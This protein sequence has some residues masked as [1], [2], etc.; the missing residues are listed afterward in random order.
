M[1]SIAPKREGAH[2]SF[3]L[4]SCLAWVDGGWFTSGLLRDGF[5]FNN[6]KY[7]LFGQQGHPVF[8]RGWRQSRRDLVGTAAAVRCLS[9]CSLSRR[10]H[11]LRLSASH[12][13]PQMPATFPNAPPHSQ[14]RPRGRPRRRYPR[15]RHRPHSRR[16]RPIRR[17]LPRRQRAPACLR[18]PPSRCR[19][20]WVCKA[21]RCHPQCHHLPPGRRPRSSHQRHPNHRATSACPCKPPPSQCYSRWASQAC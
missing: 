9:T 13:T 12:G 17:R 2:G 20:R 11:P 15:S 1:P 10:P 19:Y 16:H 21:C 7:L 3:C 5:F 18:N 6:I 4:Q 8:S 14:A